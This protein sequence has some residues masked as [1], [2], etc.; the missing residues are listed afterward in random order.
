MTGSYLNAALLSF[1]RRYI[2][3]CATLVTLLKTTINKE[4]KHDKINLVMLVKVLNVKI[5][6]C[7]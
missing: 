1:G 7:N 4:T 2:K 6:L 5:C 3:V